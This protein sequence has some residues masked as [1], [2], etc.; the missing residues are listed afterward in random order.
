MPVQ[1]AAGSGTI[2][3]VKL[4]GDVENDVAK[5]D[6]VREAVGADVMILADA[7]QGWD[8]PSAVRFS[9]AIADLGVAFIEQPVHYSNVI[10]MA[11]ANRAPVP[12]AAD[13]GVFDAA[14]LTLHTRLD[15]V[16]AVV[17]KLMKSAGPAV[18][19]AHA[20]GIGIHFAGM[21]GQSS[22]G[23]AHAV[24]LA[25][26]IPT[27]VFGAGICPYYLEA[28]IVDE[29]LTATNGALRAPESDG[30]G[31]DLDEAMLARF[32]VDL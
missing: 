30:I 15:A 3:K 5:V 10:G 22:I 2:V 9:R 20:S 23:A 32:V 27:L 29:P 14:A 17:V 4:G 6:A 19:G 24:H 16:S 18:P 26:A 28:D 11:A 31:L 25:S 13:E 1:A 7:N 8:V 12:I 21:P